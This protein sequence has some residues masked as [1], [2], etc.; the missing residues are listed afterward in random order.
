MFYNAKEADVQLK[1]GKMHY[2]S[3]GRGD[4][5]LVMI[6]GLRLSAIDG[7]SKIVSMYYRIFAKEYTVYMFDKKD[8]ISEGYTVHDLAEDTVRAIE[9]LG[10][11]DIYLFG[12]SL[13][14]MISQD[15]AI[16]HPTLVR[17]MVLAVTSS[18]TNET[19]RHVIPHWQELAEENNLIG[20]AEDYT[21]KA[22]SESYLKKY[23]LLIPLS[24]KTQKFMP[25]ERFLILAK[26]CL[27]CDTYDRLGEIICPVLVLGGG[28]DKIVSGEASR[29]IAERL[30]CECYMYDELSHEAYNEAKDFNKRIYNFFGRAERNTGYA[31]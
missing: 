21:Y 14:G 3:F 23:K 11:H 12:A 1:D 16:N 8:N 4:K 29:E 22:F 30:G 17:K 15:I 10:L 24:M 18:R 20:V 27:T 5:T 28:K 25:K 19:I 9:V 31:V 13:G 2:I 6:P 26:A 7:S